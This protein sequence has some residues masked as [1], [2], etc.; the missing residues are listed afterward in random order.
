MRFMLFVPGNSDSEA[1]QM[2]TQ[3]LIAEMM[4]PADGHNAVRIYSEVRV[5]AHRADFVVE[6]GEFHYANGKIY[7]AAI[8][9]G[10]CSDDVISTLER[11][12]VPTL[13]FT[14]RDLDA[15]PRRRALRPC[16]RHRRRASARAR[17]GPRSASRALRPRPADAEGV[18]T[19]CV[20]QPAAAGGRR[21]VNFTKPVSNSLTRAVRTHTRPRTHIPTYSSYPPS[22]ASRSLPFRLA[23]ESAARQGIRGVH[24]SGRGL[25][26]TI[27]ARPDPLAAGDR[28]SR[29]GPARFQ[30]SIDVTRE[31]S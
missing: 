3:E 2:P 10:E 14:S 13:R 18:A 23:A 25:P 28:E 12:G 30:G 19:S 1:G 8:M 26:A 16:A 29:E 11:M 27:R 24:R 20:D 7:R 21:S 4:F 6:W 9:C 5:G 15:E 31:R 22:M 17:C